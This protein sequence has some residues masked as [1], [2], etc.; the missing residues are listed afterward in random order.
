[1]RCT[2]MKPE[3]LKFYRYY[4]KCKRGQLGSGNHIVVTGRPTVGTHLTELTN[5]NLTRL[6]CCLK[7]LLEISSMS[8]T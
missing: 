8:L 7:L 4:I 3:I 1:M 2:I 5:N 6:Q